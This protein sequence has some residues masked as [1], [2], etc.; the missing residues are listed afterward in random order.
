MRLH[1]RG[2]TALAISGAVVSGVVALAPAATAGAP[3]ITKGYATFSPGRVTTV[4]TAGSPAGVRFAF[5]WDARKL[6]GE[7]H[8]RSVLSLI[9]PSDGSVV[10]VRHAAATITA[11]DTGRYRHLFAVPASARG[12]DVRLTLSSTQ[13]S[14]Y[15][16][17]ET[18]SRVSC[19]NPSYAPVLPT[20]TAGHVTCDGKLHITYDNTNGSQT[21]RFRYRFQPGVS[22]PGT[23][24]IKPGTIVRS[25]VTHLA[26]DSPPWLLVRMK[27]G[28]VTQHHL[29]AALV[30]AYRTKL[31][32]NC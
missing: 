31:P 3:P 29:D 8:V 32:S 5:D 25:T 14:S 21:W 30:A 7:Y 10:L 15:D 17:V 22:S 27:T 12:K 13:G 6:A 24:I 23:A 19:A 16:Y 28:S 2:L 4:C 11:G 26:S 20:I 1:R 18:L 9:R